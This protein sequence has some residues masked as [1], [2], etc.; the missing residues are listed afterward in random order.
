MKKKVY[1][2]RHGQTLFNKKN[3]IQGWCDSPLTPLGHAQA[4]A[5]KAYFEKRGIRFDKACCSTLHRTE[6]TL[7]DITSMPYSR[8]EDL[9]E[10]HYGDLEGESTDLGCKK[11]DDL[12]TF[13]VAH[14]GE[15]PKE[16]EDRVERAIRHLVEEDDA[17]SILIV[18]HGSNS[19]R[20]ANR[21]EPKRARKMRKFANCVIYEYEYEDGTFHLLDVI[22]EHVK[23]IKD[24]IE[25]K[26]R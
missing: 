20:F 5:T 22:D 19:F 14:G 17:Q 8:N 11:G 1:I 3:K 18:A 2:V 12:N 15:S 9:K 4:R 6:E 16:V 7:K 10:F 21:V 13:Y 26:S 24:P 23:D 25:K